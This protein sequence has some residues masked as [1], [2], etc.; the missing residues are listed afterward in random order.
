M[1]KSLR[2][3]EEPALVGFCVVLSGT[4]PQSFRFLENGRQDRMDSMADCFRQSSKTPEVRGELSKDV[5]Q[6]TRR[7]EFNLYWRMSSFC[8]R[9][10]GVL[11]KCQAAGR[12][13]GPKHLIISEMLSHCLSLRM[14]AAL[15]IRHVTR[16]FCLIRSQIDSKTGLGLFDR[17]WHTGSVQR[18]ERTHCALKGLQ[19]V[20]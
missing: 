18:Q 10:C 2:F 20:L 15:D 5:T 1:C 17:R 14:I 16:L 19:A 12:I 8:K 6:I 13:T 7:A 9:V 3:S 4:Q 11:R